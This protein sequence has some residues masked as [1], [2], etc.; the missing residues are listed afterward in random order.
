ML[1]HLNMSFLKNNI[2][3]YGNDSFYEQGFIYNENEMPRY[4]STIISR[5][6]E[7]TSWIEN[8]F[9]NDLKDINGVYIMDCRLDDNITNDF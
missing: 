7:D 8:E 1:T 6:D 9:S 5:N 4:V 3:K 2:G